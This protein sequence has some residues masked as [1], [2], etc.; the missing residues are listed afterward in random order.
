MNIH[1]KSFVIPELQARE[2]E[3]VNDS[4]KS[5]FRSL[6]NSIAS[7]FINIDGFAYLTARQNA[8][9][10]DYFHKSNFLAAFERVAGI[11]VRQIFEDE[12]LKTVI[13]AHVKENV[14]LI[15][16]IPKEY[17]QRV[18]NVV[19]EGIS[20][21]L[22]SGTIAKQ[23]LTQ[24]KDAKNIGVLGITQ[25]RAKII[26]RDQTAKLN[27]QVN[28]KR[29]QN[30]GITDYK[31]RTSKDNRVRHAHRE[32]EGVQFSWKDPSNRPPDGLDPGQPILCRCVAE[33]VVIF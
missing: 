14:D 6:I 3:Y 19:L 27:G 11:N 7:N 13:D 12:K 5:D 33:A 22:S 28:S 10:V 25:R 24:G 26:A 4:A 23:L 1:I 18:Q 20:D 30:L 16:S 31:W 9:D 17:F 32:L 8:V 21:G 29:Q 2:S 15:K